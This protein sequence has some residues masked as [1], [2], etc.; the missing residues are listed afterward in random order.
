MTTNDPDPFF[1]G[2]PFDRSAQERAAAAEAHIVDPL[3]VGDI[4]QIRAELVADPQ[5]YAPLREIAQLL[6]GNTGPVYRISRNDERGD[7]PTL[8]FRDELNFIRRPGDTLGEFLEAQHQASVEEFIAE[9]PTSFDAP[10]PAGFENGAR[11]RATNPVYPN[12]F[13]REG[14]VVAYDPTTAYFEVVLDGDIAAGIVTFGPESDWEPLAVAIPE[15]T[16]GPWEESVEPQ[17]DDQIRKGRPLFF[18]CM[19][20]FPDALLAVAQLSR[21][22]NEQHNPGEPMHWSREKS[23]GH[24]DSAARHMLEAGTID[25]SDGQLHSAHLAWRALAN[26]QLEIEDL[27]ERGLWT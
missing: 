26:L 3:R 13:G 15:T 23:S 4:V 17:N 24:L 2:T 22:A 19:R 9:E 11:V 25:P 14:E 27:R 5:G 20:Y 16:A 12:T 18:G 8:F 21:V 6:A 1:D 7:L 10:R